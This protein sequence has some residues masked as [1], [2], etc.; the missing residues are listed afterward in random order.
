MVN[1]F[2]YSAKNSELHS[3]GNTV[4]L[5]NLHHV[6]MVGFFSLVVYKWLMH[7]SGYFQCPKG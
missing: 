3:A 5:T 2:N 4:I 6:Y 7:I 1:K